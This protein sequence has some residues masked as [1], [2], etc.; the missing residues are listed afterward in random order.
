MM[1]V[2]FLGTGAAAI[3]TGFADGPFEI[4]LGLAA[5]GLFASIYNPVG[6]A[7]VTR[8]PVNRGCALGLN[9]IFGSAG[10]AGGAGVA[11]RLAEALAGHWGV[12][13]PGELRRH[14]GHGW[15]AWILGGG[16]GDAGGDGNSVG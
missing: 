10:T 6:I 9:G 1:A 16:V 7:W 11:G 3:G 2:F 12:I 4:A 5:I 14:I 8:N 15:G 13:V